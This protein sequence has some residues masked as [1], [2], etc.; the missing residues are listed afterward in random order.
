[1]SILVDI[2][3]YNANSRD[4]N[5]YLRK[6]SVIDGATLRL[7]GYIGS[8]DYGISEIINKIQGKIENSKVDNRTGYSFEI[9][10]IFN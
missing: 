3:H 4:K 1:M 8:I 7:Y 2:T 10:Q 9:H 5:T 6:F